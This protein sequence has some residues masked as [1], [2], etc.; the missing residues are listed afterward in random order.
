MPLVR[1]LASGRLLARMMRV[2]GPFSKGG[3]QRAC[4]ERARLTREPTGPLKPDSPQQ[5]MI[6]GRLSHGRAGN[7]R[8]EGRDE[9]QGRTIT[10]G[11]SAIDH[12][13]WQHLN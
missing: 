10:A 3:G 9:D 13:F 12:G 4:G 8:G 6:A 2:T 7:R 5:E 1:L 11:F